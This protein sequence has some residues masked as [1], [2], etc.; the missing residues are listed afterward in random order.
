MKKIR[1]WFTQVSSP[2]SKFSDEYLGY[3]LWVHI[4]TIVTV[5]IWTGLIFIV[6]VLLNIE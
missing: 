1:L 3:P 2:E 5:L 4:L 6:V